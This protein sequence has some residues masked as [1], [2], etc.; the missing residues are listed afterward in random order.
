MRRKICIHLAGSGNTCASHVTGCNNYRT[1]SEQAE[2][3]YGWQHYGWTCCEWWCRRWSCSCYCYNEHWRLR[4]WQTRYFC[5]LPGQNENPVTRGG[6]RSKLFIKFTIES[7]YE[8]RLHLLLLII[9]P[10]STANEML[11]FLCV[12]HFWMCVRLF[13][14]WKFAYK[15]LNFSSLIQCLN[16]FQCFVLVLCETYEHTN[17][18]SLYTVKTRAVNLLGIPYKA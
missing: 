4:R 8:L 17:K 3:S 14:T 15:D 10:L 18:E 16:I 1:W 2:A 11:S 5:Q 12:M 6:A 13:Y 7:N 9:W